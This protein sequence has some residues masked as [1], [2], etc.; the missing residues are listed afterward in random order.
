MNKTVLLIAP[1]FLV[2]V[3]VEISAAEFRGSRH[4]GSLRKSGGFH[5]SFGSRGSH[6]ASRDIHH[7]RFHHF[8]HRH[9]HHKKVFVP[10]HHFGHHHVIIPRHGLRG[11]F[12]FGQRVISVHPSSVVIWSHPG[13]LAGFS[14]PPPERIIDEERILEG[15]LITMMLRNRHELRLSQQQV[16]DLENV[17][18]GYQREAIHYEADV[19]IAEMDLQRLLEAAVVDLDQVKVK[20][21]QIEHLKTELRL[22]RIRAIEQGKALLSPEQHQK[23]QSLLG[24]SRYSQV[25][26]ERFTGPTEDQP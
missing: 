9:F 3:F 22:A 13:T 4:R 5:A 6:L 16:Q 19:R 15:P 18:D 1:I 17:R 11:G 21:Q 25:G 8:G 14:V 24:D 23:L 10:H 12:F 20:L 26:D 2:L 7:H